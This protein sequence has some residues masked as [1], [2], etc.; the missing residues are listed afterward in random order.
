MNLKRQQE[1]LQELEVLIPIARKIEAQDSFEDFIRL[2]FTSHKL[3]KSPAFHLEMIRLMALLAQNK[4]LSP[5]HQED[6][7]EHKE[8]AK[9]GTQGNST[10][11][12][13][14]GGEG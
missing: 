11:I 4:S 6:R 12:N 9:E 2:Y 5:T 3:A 1:I 10:Q 13:K 7:A 8:E 14:E